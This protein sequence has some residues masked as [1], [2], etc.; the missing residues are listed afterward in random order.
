MNSLGHLLFTILS[1]RDIRPTA[2]LADPA[3]P[4]RRVPGFLILY[5]APTG[6]ST[7]TIAWWM[8]PTVTLKILDGHQYPW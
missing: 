4:A 2:V 3:C 8:P 1:T 7:S 6:R 5:A